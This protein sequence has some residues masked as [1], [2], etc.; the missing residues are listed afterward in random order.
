VQSTFVQ[1]TKALNVDEIDPKELLLLEDAFK[2]I[3]KKERK[4]DFECLHSF[5]NHPLQT[6][7][8]KQ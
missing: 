6:G 3:S 8:I 5:N 4:N 2:F 7:F 1:K